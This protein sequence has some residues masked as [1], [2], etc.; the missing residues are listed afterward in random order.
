LR[1]VSEPLEPRQLLA[2]TPIARPDSLA[3]L[4]N[5][6][7]T[8]SAQ[9]TFVRLTGNSSA[10]TGDLLLTP[11]TGSITAGFWGYWIG[12][13]AH[14]PAPRGNE[15]WA[16]RLMGGQDL[17]PGRYVDSDPTPYASTNTQIE[18]NDLSNP[19]HG[20]PHTGEFTIWQH[21]LGIVQTGPYQDL[22]TIHFVADFVFHGRDGDVSGRIAYHRTSG[23]LDNDTFSGVDPENL[24]VSVSEPPAHGNLVQVVPGV[25]TYVPD[26]DFHGIDS[27]AYT[28]TDGNG[29]SV[30]AAV[31]LAVTPVNN[32]PTF[33]IGSDPVI[34][35]DAGA[36]AISGWAHGIAAG[37]ADESWQSLKFNV[38]GNSKPA[39]FSAGPAI[40]PVTGAL[41]FTPAANASGTAIVSLVLTDNGGTVDGGVDTSGV[42]TF[43]ITVN[44][45]NDAPTF[46]KGADVEVPVLSGAWSFAGWATAISPG[47]PDEAGQHLAFGVVGNSNP[48]LFSAGPIIDPATGTLTFTPAV[49]AGGTATISVVLQDDGGVVNGGDDTSD[50]QM[51]TVTVR[52]APPAAVAAVDAKALGAV[53]AAG[54]RSPKPAFVNVT[55]TNP[56]ASATY[57]GRA[58][59]KVL[60][61]PMAGGPDILIGQVPAALTLARGRSKVIKVKVTVPAGVPEGEYRATATVSGGRITVEGDTAG[62]AAGTVTVRRAYVQLTA[63]AGVPPRTVPIGRSAVL[64]IPVTNTGSVSATGPV[65]L[66]VYATPPGFGRAIPFKRLSASLKVAPGATQVL[67]VQLGTTGRVDVGTWVFDVYVA[68]LGALAGQEAM[69]VQIPMIVG[70]GWQFP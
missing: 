69:D 27:F 37:P 32:A 35:E 54:Y 49:G 14:K 7:I 33:L 47:S 12:I 19:D 65:R 26:P 41:T 5:H 68:P 18:F 13:D 50:V 29:V 10:F 2:G 59:V 44:P 52:P 23:L 43:T 46:T 24:V 57:S 55:V 56:L 21:E 38:T 66:T 9:R 61:S 51:F 20:A 1:V 17:P 36:Q 15:I 30:P 70:N 4:E 16:W 34:L 53:V 22:D 6:S 60:L 39:L 11:E 31:T 64:E 40:D 42:Q 48:G 67:R 58:T 8:F 63:P 28:L 25:F 3:V 62:Q 45:V